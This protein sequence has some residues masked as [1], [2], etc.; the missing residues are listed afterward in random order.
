MLSNIF[1]NSYASLCGILSNQK[2][3]AKTER[4]LKTLDNSQNKEII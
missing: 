1:K 3:K 2:N 4:H